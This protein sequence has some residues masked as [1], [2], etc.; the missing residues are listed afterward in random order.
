MHKFSHHLLYS[1]V[2]LY[3]FG[4]TCYADSINY[5]VIVN[6]RVIN[7]PND[8]AKWYVSVVGNIDDVKYNEILGWFDTNEKLIDFK[9][10]I[11]FC[12]VTSDTTIY[13]ERYADNIKVLPT[14][15]VQQPDGT[16]VYESSGKNIPISPEGLYSAVAK[17]VERILPW[18]NK[19]EDRCRPQP[20][21]TPQPIPT[22]DPEPQPID[23]GG[24]PI[25]DTPSKSKCPARVAVGVLLVSIVLGTVAG[26]ASTWKKTY[27]KS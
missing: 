11:H 9:K 20:Q 24:P 22:P 7:L 2:L 16:I 14:I 23:D 6:E 8:Q 25:I 19:M 4:T 10:Q 27:R 5:G 17:S 26:L 12:P 3:C 13:I 15:R 1:V 21:P 18:R